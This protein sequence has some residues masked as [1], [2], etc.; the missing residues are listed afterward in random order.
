MRRDTPAY[1]IL[2]CSRGFKFQAG[3]SS[4]FSCLSSIDKQSLTTV[5][6]IITLTF[7]CTVCIQ[8]A[9]LVSSHTFK[10]HCN[11]SDLVLL[12]EVHYMWTHLSHLCGHSCS[13]SHSLSV[14]PEWP[15]AWHNRKRNLIS[16]CASP[17]EPFLAFG[18]CMFRNILQERN[19]NT[20]L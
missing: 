13:C 2:T 7:T 6:T 5:H 18:H 10:Y 4:W 16:P 12:R 19:G 15:L 14:K 20:K 8:R 3:C 9:V 17:L 1:R 11:Y